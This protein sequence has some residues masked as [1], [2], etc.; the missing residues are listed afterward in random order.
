MGS[1]S[2]LADLPEELDQ[3]TFKNICGDRY[4]ESLFDALK[5]DRGVVSKAAFV[6]ELMTKTHVFLT[7][8]WG[9]DELGRNNHERVAKVN[10]WLKLHGVVTWFDSERMKGNIVQQM[11]NGIDNCQ[12]VIVIVTKNYMDKVAGKSAAGLGDNCFKEYDYA[13]R[14]KTSANML[15]VVHENRCRIPKEWIGPLGLLGG[16]LYCDNVDDDKFES[17]MNDLLLKIKALIPSSEFN[18]LLPDQAKT[19]ATSAL[20]GSASAPGLSQ[21]GGGVFSIDEEQRKCEEDMTQWMCT[22][23]RIHPANA[24][25]YAQ[26]LYK[27]GIPT[28]ERLGR[29]LAKDPTWLN[30]LK[31]DEEDAEDIGA[32]FV[33]IDQDARSVI[34]EAEATTQKI[35]T[36]AQ[37]ARRRAEQEL[38]AT[39]KKIE[40]EH[41]AW[42]ESVLAIVQSAAALALA[43]AEKSKAV[44]SQATTEAAK[45]RANNVAGTHEYNRLKNLKVVRHKNG[46]V[47]EGWHSYPTETYGSPDGVGVYQWSNNNI[48]EGMWL[49]AS[50]SGHGVQRWAIGDFYE[51]EWTENKQ[52][53]YGVK[54]WAN[55]DVYEGEWRNDKKNG[56]GIYRWATGDVYEGMWMND[57][58]N[59]H[60]VQRFANGDVYEGGWEGDKKNSRGV[61]RSANGDVYE[62][63]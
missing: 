2:S 56:R 14:R 53:V 23:A 54:R 13:E 21:A 63:M 7:H 44:A 48:Y 39:R 52:E 15:A 33:K 9:T 4:D 24:M 42:K 12:V 32:A 8:D 18:R 11:F 34:N 22:N 61:L 51:G 46:D 59:G 38:T 28:M 20:V 1:A 30:Q 6:S 43:A 29:K 50:R 5:N 37:E 31:M 10:A 45:A 26:Q 49:A 19:T 55:G 27:V 35:T 41:A 17:N 16:S 3:A 60:G 40:E 62:G 58:R 47:Y 25:N 36:E 57:Q